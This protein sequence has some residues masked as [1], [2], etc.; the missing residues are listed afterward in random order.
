MHIGVVGKGVVGGRALRL[1]RTHEA[2]T[3]TELFSD[4]RKRLR[5]YLR[6][7]R[8]P[9]VDVAILTAPQQVSTASRYLAQGI[10]VIT[11]ADSLGEV[12]NL[13]ALDSLAKENRAALVLGAT[14][15]PGLSCML[16]AK[17]ASEF[18]LVEEIHV[19]RTGA[20]GRACAK[21][22]HRS[23][24]QGALEWYEGRWR[25]RSG[26]SGR[27]LCWFPD[28]VGPADCCMAGLP[29]PLLLQPSYPRARR[30]VS[31]RAANRQDRWTSKFPM[32]TPPPAE[33]GVGA[34]RVEVRGRKDGEPAQTVL[35]AVAK[36]GAAA[37]AVAVE[38]A[39]KLASGEFVLEGASGLLGLLDPHTFLKAMRSQGV[40]LWRYA[41]SEL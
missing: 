35:G 26:G 21:S 32:L 22:Y 23:L 13:L 11:T 24:R 34:V 40:S 16:A 29:E 27:E 6:K 9:E 28:P 19:S 25:N 20:G 30:I 4:Q 1:L 33:G 14:F 36:P 7:L 3:A 38:V 37:A 5:P 18:Q 8:Q 10:S 31:R 15:S 41:G 12:K 39:L 2:V 17:A